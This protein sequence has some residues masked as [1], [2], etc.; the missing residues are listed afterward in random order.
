MVDRWARWPLNRRQL[1]VRVLIFK[2]LTVMAQIITHLPSK[3]P[4][5]VSFFMFDCCRRKRHGVLRAL[6]SIYLHGLVQLR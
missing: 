1:S 3:L 2:N 4:L 5:S 6:L